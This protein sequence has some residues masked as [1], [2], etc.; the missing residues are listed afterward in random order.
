MAKKK[1]ERKRLSELLEAFKIEDNYAKIQ[2][3]TGQVY[4]CKE[5][6]TK[7]IH[8]EHSNYS[9]TIKKEEKQKLLEEGFEELT[10]QGKIPDIIHKTEM[11]DYEMW[12]GMPVYHRYYSI[13]FY[14]II[15]KLDKW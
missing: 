10:N 1:K 14:Q 6:L 8:E 9:L 2:S 4:I 3:H 7:G 15:T 12:D 11:E 5:L 13:K